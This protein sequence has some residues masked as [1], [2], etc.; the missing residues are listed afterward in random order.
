MDAARQRQLLAVAINTMYRRLLVAD[1]T[2]T[3]PA[4]LE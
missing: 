1:D 4:E 3:L 2:R